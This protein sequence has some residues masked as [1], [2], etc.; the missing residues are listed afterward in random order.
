ME[1]AMEVILRHEPETPLVMRK[2]AHF[3]F[4]ALI[5]IVIS[6][7]RSLTPVNYANRQWHIS[8]S[9]GQIIDRDTTYRMTF[10]D[11]LIPQD[12]TIISCADSTA[13]Y[14]GMERYIAEIL[15]TAGLQDDEVLL[16]S[17]V[18]GKIFVRLLNEP[19]A[20]R[21]SSVT[22]NMQAL[23]TDNSNE[24]PYTMWIYDD[25]VEDWRRGADEMY[26]YT[27]FDKKRQ[28]VLVVDF[29]DY[30]ET[31]MAQIFVYQSRNGMTDRMQL[32]TQKQLWDFSKHDLRDYRR[33]VEFWSYLI[34]GHRANAFGNYIIGQEQLNRRK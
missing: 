34:N 28:R 21:P 24:H 22:S 8:D 18:H 30:G 16:Y 4:M 13:K 23:V 3:I 15:K 33:D 11:V 6:S 10:G 32:S 17:P 14:R 19:Q 5:I 26:T 25:D 9:Y 2:I 29:Y 1:C 31:P 7:C 12:L 27:Y 20:R